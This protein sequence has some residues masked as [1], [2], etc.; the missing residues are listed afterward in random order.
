ME[1]YSRQR[2]EILNLIKQS[3]EHPTAE[4]I[5][6]DVKEIHPHISRGTVYRNLNYLTEKGAIIKISMQ[7]GP[8][9][10]DYLRTEHKHAICTKCSKVFDFNYDFDKEN[11]EKEIQ[12]KTGLEFQIEDVIVKGICR[13]CKN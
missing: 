12:E 8:D 10:Y 6:L 5:Y 9:R 13:N 1:K 3:S 11:L 4:E 7:D 2:E